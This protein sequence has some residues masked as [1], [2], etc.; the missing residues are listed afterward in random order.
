[1]DRQVTTSR[2]PQASGRACRAEPA[3]GQSIT[4]NN[5]QTRGNAMQSKAEIDEILRQKSDAQEIPGVVAIA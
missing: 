3:G 5:N 4:A 2:P 1:M